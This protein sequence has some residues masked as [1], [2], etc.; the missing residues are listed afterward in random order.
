MCRWIADNGGRD[1]TGRSGSSKAKDTDPT[2]SRAKA[3]R[4]PTN[5]DGF[6]IG[7]TINLI[8][9]CS[10]AYG[11]PGMIWTFLSQSHIESPL[12]MAHVRAT[13]L[14]PFKKPTAIP[15]VTSSLALRPHRFEIAF[16]AAL[17]EKIAPKYFA[18]LRG[19]R[20]QGM[21]HLSTHSG[22]GQRMLPAAIAAMVRLVDS[23]RQENGVDEALDDPR[24]LHRRIFRVSATVASAKERRCIVP[25][26][27]RSDPEIATKVGRFA[28]CLVS[29]PIGNF[30]DLE[31]DPGKL[32][33]FHA[34]HT[35]T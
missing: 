24:H 33:G 29:E 8:P 21:F 9:A 15:S 28:A 25:A 18:S 34:G 20:L 32:A 26:W 16:S 14:A 11:R 13:S 6:G 7:W 30:Q 3:P 2:E 27:T 23:N 22:F 4:T 19:H 31:T 17:L 12:F 5:G 35:R 10:A 1:F